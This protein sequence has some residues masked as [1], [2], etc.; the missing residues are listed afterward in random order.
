M[1]PKSSQPWL[2]LALSMLLTLLS[3]CS[4]VSPPSGLVQFPVPPPLPKEAR[5]PPPETDGTC[6]PTCS[7]WLSKLL[8]GLGNSATMP[9]APASTPKGI[10]T[11]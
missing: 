9:A 1:K 10:T 6:V 5:Q 8:D 3:A 11:R 7:E 2:P 4:S